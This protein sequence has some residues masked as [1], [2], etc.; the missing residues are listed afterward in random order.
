M[1]YKLSLNPCLPIC[2]TPE[3]LAQSVAQ[4]R[5][6]GFALGVKLVRGAYHGHEIEVHKA[7]RDSRET[8]T[9]P[10]G[11]HTLSISPDN[12]PPVW[13]A[14]EETDTCY[15]DSVRTLLALVREDVGAGK[16][17][18]A[19]IGALFGTHNWASANLVV[20]E[21]VKLGLAT[22]EQDDVVRVSDAAMQRVAV[23]Q[24]YGEYASSLSPPFVSD[25]NTG[26]SDELSDHLV[27]RARS[28]SPFVLKYLPY[29]SLTEVC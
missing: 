10:A 25:G 27:R 19:A 17:G 21:M 14:K 7:A 29:G 18:V 28:S 15:D 16:G 26:M 2:R 23:A 3:Y 6:E 22:H 24:L 11:S 9:T 13:L 4:A 20:D 8:R 5:A 1:P 12:L